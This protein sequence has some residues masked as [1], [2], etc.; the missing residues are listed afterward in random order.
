MPTISL[1]IADNQKFANKVLSENG[2][3]K[4]TRAKLSLAFGLQKAVEEL[5]QDSQQMAKMS[6]ICFSLIDGQGV[7]RITS[8]MKQLE[9][10]LL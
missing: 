10:K 2:A 9:Q 8:T 1:A 7:N 5:I 4:L 6:E 3:I